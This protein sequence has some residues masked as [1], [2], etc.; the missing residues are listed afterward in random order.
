V[1]D[2]RIFKG[3]HLK[4]ILFIDNYVYSFAF[5]LENGIPVVPFMGD[6]NDKELIKIIRYLKFVSGSE[7]M[8]IHNKRLFQLKKIL[9][10]N[11]ESY[12]KYY[13]YELLSDKSVFFSA[14]EEDFPESPNFEPKDYS[15][16]LDHM[17]EVDSL[18][19]PTLQRKVSTNLPIISIKALA[20]SDSQNSPQERR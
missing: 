7:D 6:P 20:G 18:E 2:L 11:I 19:S 12:I 14:S 9:N 5:Q 8:R 17:S 1:K 16:R 10:S 4:N 15:F 3:I 13:N